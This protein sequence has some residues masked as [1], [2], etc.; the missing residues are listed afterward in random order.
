[1]RLH[2][3][4]S[5]Y[6]CLHTM[7][8]KHKIVSLLAR[9]GFVKSIRSLSI[10]LLRFI[11]TTTA[12][13]LPLISHLTFITPNERTLVGKE[14][15]K[16]LWSAQAVVLVPGDEDRATELLFSKLVIILVIIFQVAMGIFTRECREGA[17]SL[18]LSSRSVWISIILDKGLQSICD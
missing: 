4:N 13:I 17:H 12:L 3:T 15:E 11:F 16:L 6:K 14:F 8:L 9:L 2:N 1:M 10:V 5:L 7:F 18:R